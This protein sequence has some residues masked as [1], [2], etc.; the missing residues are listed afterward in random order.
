[1]TSATFPTPYM[2]MVK[3]ILAGKTRNKDAENQVP[4][5]QICAE[6]S[7]AQTIPAIV[8]NPQDVPVRAKG[9]RDHLPNYGNGFWKAA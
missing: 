8:T 2:R 1:M 7:P 4:S 9:V 6:P 3:E 5:F